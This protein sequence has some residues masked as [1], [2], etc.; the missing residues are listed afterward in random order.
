MTFLLDNFL[1]AKVYW[2]AR[3][4]ASSPLGNHH[5]LVFIPDNPDDFNNLRNYFGGN[6][7]YTIGGFKVHQY[8]NYQLNNS[9]DEEAI[10][11][12]FGGFDK[13]WDPEFCEI[14]RPANMTDTEFIKKLQTIANSYQNDTVL[15][16]LNDENCA[17]WVNTLLMIAGISDHD[18]EK[19]GEFYGFDW[20][21]EDLLPRK[22]FKYE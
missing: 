22:S 16:D 6:K 4:L 2:C 10:N 14:S 13:G 18:R 11:E 1:G 19:Y 20:G 9:V 21:E 12:Y 7:G 5:F 3:D 8:L 15:Y 17:A